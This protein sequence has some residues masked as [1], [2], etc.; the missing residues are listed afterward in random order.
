MG[1][2]LGKGGSG[3]GA[4]LCIGAVEPTFDNASKIICIVLTEE[5]SSHSGFDALKFRT[6]PGQVV[7]SNYRAAKRQSMHGGEPHIARR[8]A[9][10]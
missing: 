1:I 7:V 8:H 9:E 3:S 2:N 4:T 5:I 6:L 10:G